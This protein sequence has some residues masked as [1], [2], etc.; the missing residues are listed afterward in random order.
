MRVIDTE[1]EAVIDTET[2]AFRPWNTD[3]M[4]AVVEQGPGFVAV[5]YDHDPAK[6]YTFKTSEI[7]KVGRF[8]QRADF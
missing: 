2:E 5:K 1:T 8:V 7:E 4:G 3:S 6:V